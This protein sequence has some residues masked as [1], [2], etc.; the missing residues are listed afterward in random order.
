MVLN[1]KLWYLTIFYKLYKCIPNDLK[2]K[3]SLLV[4][5]GYNFKSDKFQLILIALLSNED[6]DIYIN[7]YNFLYNTYNF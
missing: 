7:L 2:G 4:L 5:M 1:L 6:T 3:Y